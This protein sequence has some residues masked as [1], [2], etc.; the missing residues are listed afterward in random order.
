QLRLPHCSNSTLFP[1]TTLFRSN[2][3]LES[4]ITQLCEQVCLFLNWDVGLYWRM[5]KTKTKLHN[6]L[7]I[8]FTYKD[9]SQF[10]EAN[11]RVSFSKGEGLVGYVWVNKK[12]RWIDV[13]G[14]MDMAIRQQIIR[15]TGFVSNL[16]FPILD[17]NEVTG[18]LEF[19]STNSNQ[20]DE[21]MIEMFESLGL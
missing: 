19:F 4:T 21:N 2:K 14:S 15:E 1:Y 18:V 16:C 3:D 7:I 13:L 8:P 20:S 9:I 6:P 10:N 12:P 17:N 11:N 5:D